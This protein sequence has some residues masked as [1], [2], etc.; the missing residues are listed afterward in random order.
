LFVVVLEE[1][2]GVLLLGYRV[3]DA[4]AV[5]FVGEICNENLK[6]NAISELNQS[7]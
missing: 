4:A 3:F 7:I 2:D 1:A 6:K 5:G